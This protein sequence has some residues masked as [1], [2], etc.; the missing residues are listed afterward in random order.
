MGGPFFLD[1][2]TKPS[3]P[4]FLFHENK[5]Y[6]SMV[7]FAKKKKIHDIIWKTWRSW[8]LEWIFL[9]IITDN[10]MI[11]GNRSISYLIERGVFALVQPTQ[12][13]RSAAL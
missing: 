3:G 1:R 9:R 11:S 12:A 8:T 7:L 6:T 4:V 13:H 2:D 5:V 10:H